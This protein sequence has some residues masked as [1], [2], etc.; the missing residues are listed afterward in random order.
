MTTTLTLTATLRAFNR[1][2]VVVV[3]I[4]VWKFPYS[5]D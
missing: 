3:M 1:V 4:A 2:V 5:E